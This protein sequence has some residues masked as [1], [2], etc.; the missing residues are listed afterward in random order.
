MKYNILKKIVALLI[1]TLIITFWTMHV[2]KRTFINSFIPIF[3][4]LT[5]IYLIID[6]SVKRF[7]KDENNRDK[8]KNS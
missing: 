7:K 3:I 2:D 1:A 4:T 6:F 8:Q 5:I